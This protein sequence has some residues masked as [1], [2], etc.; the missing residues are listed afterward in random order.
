MNFHDEF[1][2]TCVKVK[3]I[4]IIDTKLVFFLISW[5]LEIHEFPAAQI[6]N[7]EDSSFQFLVL[8]LR[9]NP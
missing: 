8:N 1:E 7:K 5:K 4:K 9:L 6:K 2:Y 3:V